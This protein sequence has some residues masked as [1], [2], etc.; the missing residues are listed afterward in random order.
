MEV[1]LREGLARLVERLEGKGAI[2]IDLQR[3]SGGASL[4]TWSFIAQGAARKDLI[5]RRRAKPLEAESGAVN[6]AS[7]AAVLRAV[8]ANGAPVPELVHLCDETDGLGEAHVTR[9][10]T[11]ETLGRKI[12]ADNRFD[13]VRGK[14][15]RQCGQVLAKIHGTSPPVTELRVSGALAELDL[16]EDAYRTAG[17]ER[18]VLELALRHLR[19]HAPQVASPALVHGD[20][21]NGNLMID[22][23]IGLV[24]VLDWEVTHLG[25]PAEDLGWICMNSWRF[26]RPDRPVGGFGEYEDLL[27]GYEEGGGKPVSLSQVRYWQAVGTLKWAVTCLMM[28]KSW[29]D[30]ETSSVERPVIGRRISETEID[31]LNLL[32]G[33][34]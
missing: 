30:G 1:D 7:E 31:L 3:L 26:G 19:T 12:V 20:F 6:L 29:A 33:G 8:A 32:E 10:V 13:A 24:A 11:G 27:A 4:E 16:Y 9:R 15:A 21:R 23:Q 14:L 25:D 34:L 17:A 22:P 5:L 2:L 28:Y 18:P